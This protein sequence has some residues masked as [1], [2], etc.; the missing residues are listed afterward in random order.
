MLA[1]QPILWIPT[2]I[3]FNFL[4]RR[5][6]IL[7]E[8][9]SKV[10][11]KMPPNYGVVSGL[12]AFLMQ[13]VIFTPPKVNWY[14]RGTLAALNYKRNCDTFGMFFIDLEDPNQPWFIE[15]IPEVHSVDVVRELKLTKLRPRK[16]QPERQDDDETTYPLGNAPTWKEIAGSLRSNPTILIPNWKE[17]LEINWYGDCAP[18]TAESYAVEIFIRFTC[19]LWILLNPSWRRRPENHINPMALGDA[20]NYWSVDSILEEVLD[21]EFKPC[22]SGPHTGPGRPSLSFSE[23]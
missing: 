2:Q 20:L 13:S 15:S 4:S 9:H 7:Y 16:P 10:W 21:T 19:H 14:V 1:S 23:R 17:P 3:W 6:K 18:G 11:G 12:Y 8:A 22:H 5:L